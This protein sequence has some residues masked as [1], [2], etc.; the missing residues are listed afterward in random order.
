MIKKNPWTCKIT[1]LQVPKSDYSKVIIVCTANI[2]F[3]CGNFVYWFTAFVSLCNLLQCR[4]K[5]QI[6]IHKLVFL[7]IYWWHKFVGPQQWNSKKGKLLTQSY[8]PLSKHDIHVP[9]I[10]RDVQ[11]FFFRNGHIKL[12]RLIFFFKS[13]E[14]IPRPEKVDKR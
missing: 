11:H 10:L 1:F 2:A 6:D 14:N 4:F 13:T 8:C 5:V 12:I 9:L 7:C 3:V